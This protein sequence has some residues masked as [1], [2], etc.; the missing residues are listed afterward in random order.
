MI[1]PGRRFARCALVVVGV[2]LCLFGSNR[3]QDSGHASGSQLGGTPVV[4]GSTPSVG[5]HA[6]APRSISSSV[7][8]WVHIVGMGAVAALAAA[9]MAWTALAAERRRVTVATVANSW[10]RRGPPVTRI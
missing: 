6:L 4:T 10:R 3:L 7:E 1:V 9:A 2:A 8:G 5:G